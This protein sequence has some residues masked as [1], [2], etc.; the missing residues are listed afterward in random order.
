MIRFK[1]TGE[2]IHQLPADK[3]SM[4]S[5][6]NLVW[7]GI[8][9]LV[10]MQN[11]PKTIISHPLIRTHTCAYQGVRNVSFLENVAYVLNV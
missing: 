9:H 10:R 2:M 7:Q 8:M 6:T 5:S 3:S 11:F 1:A 4:D